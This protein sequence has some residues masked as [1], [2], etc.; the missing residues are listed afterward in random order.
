MIE[1]PLDFKNLQQFFV[2]SE[3]AFRAGFVRINVASFCRF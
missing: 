1:I 3:K 2:F